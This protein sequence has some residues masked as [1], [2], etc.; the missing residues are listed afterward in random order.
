[1][2]ELARELGF[3]VGQLLDGEQWTIGDGEHTLTITRPPLLTPA[4]LRRWEILADIEAQA[5]RIAAENAKRRR[6]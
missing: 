2:F 5:A 1:M 6:G 3:T 4:E